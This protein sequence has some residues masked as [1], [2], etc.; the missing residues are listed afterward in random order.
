MF[1]ALVAGRRVF[2]AECSAP[3]L[4][5]P[6]AP[7]RACLAKFW[8]V[9][10]TRRPMRGR[11]AVALCFLLGAHIGRCAPPPGDASPQVSAPREK[12]GRDK[13]VHQKHSGAAVNPSEG[14]VQAGMSAGSEPEDA[15]PGSRPELRAGAGGRH[16]GT[17]SSHA[18]A[19]VSGKGAVKGPSAD[20]T[21]YKSVGAAKRGS[22]SP[23]PSA[24]AATSAAA[25]AVANAA[26]SGSGSSPGS[27]ILSL[28]LLCSVGAAA[29]YVH[30]NLGPGGLSSQLDRLSPLQLQLGAF[31]ILVVVQASAL[32][33][34]KLCQTSGSYEFSPAS[35]VASTEAC[36]LALAATLHWHATRPKEGAEEGRALLE[37]V[38]P[39]IVMHYFG[40]ACLYTANNQ[41][42][43]YC[44]E[45]L[46]PGTFALAKS[47]APYLVALMLW[48]TGQQLNQLQWVCI[49]LQ[50]TSIATTQ[51]DAC[52]SAGVFS[53][54]AY[55][56]AALATSITATSS[57]WNQKV[58][59]GFD[60]PVNLQNSILYV[61]GL[62]IAV[63][64]YLVKPNVADDG[65]SR[66]FFHGYSLLA[67]VLILFQAFHGL[68]VTLVYKYADAIVK[69]FANSAVMAILVVL[70]AY[71]FELHTTLHSWLGVVGVLVTT[72]AYMNIAVKM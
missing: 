35:A 2:A 62:L 23:A 15:D 4:A 53:A 31:C 44:F 67:V 61:F 47:L 48:L 22:R 71:F 12:K 34:F 60:V 20:A 11:G 55:G 9:R 3:P 25:A 37:G 63:A 21:G 19:H 26:D 10:D 13:E 45:L 17:K 66:S 5:A 46:D 27:I 30:T 24:P 68:A 33:L 29:Y 16:N 41:L 14:T 42:T 56:L 7:G 72:F 51:Y 8:L 49:I 40:L 28:A 59:K 58:V 69:N 50:C 36:K 57:V 38:S 43:F 70:S 65:D 1:H 64:S 6:R 39:R 32:L 18:G 54:K 52:K